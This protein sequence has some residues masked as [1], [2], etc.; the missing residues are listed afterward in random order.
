MSNETR[1]KIGTGLTFAT[2]LFVFLVASYLFVQFWIGYTH[3]SE[4]W[5][6]GQFT[7]VTYTLD[8]IKAFSPV[9]ATDFVLAQHIQLANVMNSGFGIAVM[10]VFGLR[11]RQK[12]AW[13]AILATA[14]WAGVNDAIAL[15]Q[16]QQP[17]LPLIGEA[18]CIVGLFIAR[19]AIFGDPATL[20]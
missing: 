16:A 5:R 9:V 14:L 17:L 11:R 8:D 10:T 13:Y 19:P 3:P 18:L 6:S 12:W 7:P 1:L 15:Y 20:R 2:G 4:P